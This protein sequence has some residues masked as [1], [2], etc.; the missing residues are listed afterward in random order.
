MKVNQTGHITFPAS[1]KGIRVVRL[2]L[3]SLGLTACAGG[4]TSSPA[5]DNTLL[6]AGSI[7][8]LADFTHQ[9]GGDHEPHRLLEC[10]ING[11][12]ILFRSYLD[13][14]FLRSSCNTS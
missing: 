2:C 8:P 10:D 3:V 13:D 6:V 11:C 7:A 4:G 12:A 5:T 14:L 1:A 9:V